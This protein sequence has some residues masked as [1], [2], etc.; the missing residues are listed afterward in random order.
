MKG[1]IKYLILLVT[2]FFVVACSSYE[3]TEAL[4]SYSDNEIYGLWVDT[5]TAQPQGYYVHQL[6]IQPNGSF[7][8]GAGII[9]TENKE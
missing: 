3:D 5:V 7:I 4:P 6:V 1:K 9:F 2:A 8:S